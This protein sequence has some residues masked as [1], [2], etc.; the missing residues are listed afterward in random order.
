M[1]KIAESI[2][3]VRNTMKLV[4]DD[5]F[6]TDRYIYSLIMKY[7]NTLIY[8]D[9]QRLNIYNNPSSF[10]EIPCFKLK[11]V[12]RIEGCC[13][14]FNTGCKIMRSVEKLPEIRNVNG[15]PII[16]YVTTL[17]GS[18]TFHKTTM[19]IYYQMSK[20]STFK[21]NKKKYYWISNGYLYVPDVDFESVRV[22]AMFS[23]DISAYTCGPACGVTDKCSYA[24]EA[25]ISIPD[26]LLSEA[27]QLALQEMLTG[28]KITPD[29]Q[30]DNQHIMRS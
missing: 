19:D 21:Y 1:V 27:E 22:S 26:H 5:A 24:Q 17:D 29:V 13:I 30:D 25:E 10:S 4:N 7:G 20:S 28:A 23:G 3:R 9:G 14:D 12:D 15:G 8:R 6:I 18:E 11:E 16:K 2:S